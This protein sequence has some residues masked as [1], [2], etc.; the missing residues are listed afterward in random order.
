MIYIHN[1]NNNHHNITRVMHCN[2][3]Y[4][5]YLPCI[6]VCKYTVLS[7]LLYVIVLYIY[8]YIYIYI[9]TVTYK[10]KWGY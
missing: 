3:F 4:F 5:I 9:Y 6:H 8:I 1:N 7:M 2:V 10:R